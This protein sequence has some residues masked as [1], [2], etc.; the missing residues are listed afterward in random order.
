ME[1]GDI[2]KAVTLAERDLKANRLSPAWKLNLA[3]LYARLGE[4]DKAR[5]MIQTA[6]QE[7]T[8]IKD[9]YAR[10]GWLR[11]MEHADWRTANEMF[12][13]DYQAERISPHWKR[14]FALTKTAQNQWDQALA[15]VEIAY[16]ESPVI[17]DGYS[18]LGWCGY[19]QG[20]GTGVYQEQAAQDR[21]LNR[22]SPSYAI[23][24]E[25]LLKVAHGQTLGLN[26]YRKIFDNPKWLTIISLTHLCQKNFDRAGELLSAIYD[27]G[28]MTPR[29]FP[30][31]AI[32][33][34]TLGQ[35]D[36]AKSVIDCMAN[37]RRSFSS[38]I[39]GASQGQHACMTL[40]QLAAAVEDRKRWFDM[41]LRYP[42]ETN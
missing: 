22:L 33:L 26:S 31:F 3:T 5:A 15:L 10:V 36:K 11:G 39:I 12:S 25:L 13:R 37:T 19:L 16:R 35:Y 29:W 27:R 17:R 4:D 14:Y 8:E 34:N 41:Q 1:S 38:V 6:Y 40:T 42:W 21:E 20:R 18:Q 7:S 32:I 9:G 2:K 30:T 28:S 24:T 23:L